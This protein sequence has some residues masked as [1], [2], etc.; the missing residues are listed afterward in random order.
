MLKERKSLLRTMAEVA[1]DLPGFLQSPAVAPRIPD[2]PI[3]GVVVWDTVGSLG[4]PAYNLKTDTQL[5]AFQFADLALS[6]KVRHGLHAVSVD[7]QRSNFTPTLWEPD[8]RI[9]QVLFPGA[10]ADVGGGYPDSESGLSDGGLQWIVEELTKLGV[11]FAAK[12]GVTLK[13]DACGIAHAPWAQVPWTLLPNGHRAFPPGLAVHRSVVE[14][15][16]GADRLR[17]AGQPVYNPESLAD[18]YVAAG[19]LKPGLRVIG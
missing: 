3:E 7:E 1:V 18:A 17:A 11:A 2:V 19:Q 16:A 5:D 14:R 13:P 10:H 9:V 6:R 4:I 15:L 12:P 8:D